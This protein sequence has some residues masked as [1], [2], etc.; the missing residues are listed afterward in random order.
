MQLKVG[1]AILGILIV[2]IAGGRLALQE[3]WIRLPGVV[4][5]EASYPIGIADD[6]VFVGM[7]HNIFIAKIIKLAGQTNGV[8]APRTTQFEVQILKNIKGS[9][10]GIVTLNQEGGYD[11]GML[12]L[13]N[14]QPLLESGRTYLLSARTDGKGSYL[15]SSYSRGAIVL[16][17]DQSFENQ[18]DVLALTKAYSEEIPYQPD[19]QSQTNFNSYSSTVKK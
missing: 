5:S 4:S 12:T 16:S 2:G 13:V 7:S 19:V 18:P 11:N 6:R 17:S 3:N 9:L 10:S 14:S 15:V 8:D 1:V